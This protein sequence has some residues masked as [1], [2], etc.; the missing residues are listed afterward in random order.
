M[1]PKSKNATSQ[2]YYIETLPLESFLFPIKE[3]VV[4]FHKIKLI[5]DTGLPFLPKSQPARME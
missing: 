5:I 4:D 1:T 2:F 3:S